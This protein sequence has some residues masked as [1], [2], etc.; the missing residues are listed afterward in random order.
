MCQYILCLFSKKTTKKNIYIYIYILCLGSLLT[1][2]IFPF[3]F[4]H[5]A[6]SSYEE[7]FSKDNP[8][9]T[10]AIEKITD[11]YVT[12]LGH[13]SKVKQSIPK[14]SGN[15]NGASSSSGSSNFNNRNNHANNDYAFTCEQ[16]EKLQED[17]EKIRKAFRDLQN[18]VNNPIKNFEHGL[19][20]ISNKLEQTT[21]VSFTTKQVRAMLSALENHVMKLRFHIPSDRKSVV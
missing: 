15:N 9:E 17:L 4:V 1:F 10:S 2:Y 19:N 14:F 6:M 18:S 21:S 20:D 5:L 3:H 16:S 11:A 7:L 8:D 12:L 13:V